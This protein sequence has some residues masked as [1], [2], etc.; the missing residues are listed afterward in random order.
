[1]VWNLV[2]TAA[3][4]DCDFVDAIRVQDQHIGV[5]GDRVRAEHTAMIELH[6]QPKCLQGNLHEHA[7]SPLLTMCIRQGVS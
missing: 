3:I 4:L 5:A 7:I 6:L 2:S 1:M